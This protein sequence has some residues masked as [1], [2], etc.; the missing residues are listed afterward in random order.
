MVGCEAAEYLAE[1]GHEVAIIEMKDVIVADV[2]PENRKYMFENFEENHVQLYPGAKVGQFYA[3]GV[4]YAK[5]DGTQGS[6]RRYDTL[7]LAM[8]TR[9]NDSLSEKVKEVVSQVVVIG[10]ALQA[11]GNAVMATGNAF[12]AAM[13]I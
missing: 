3:D 13:T 10:E 11:P 6:L 9:K 7:V 1:R 12:D 8:G 2:V 4:D 5:K